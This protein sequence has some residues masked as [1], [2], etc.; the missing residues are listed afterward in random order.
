M[1]VGGLVTG[2][3]TADLVEQLLAIERRPMVQ[4][5]QRKDVLSKQRDAWRDINS[6]LNTLRERM[7]SL[8]TDKLFVSRAATASNESVL[9]VSAGSKAVSGSYEI[10]VVQLAKAHTVHLEPDQN[11]NFPDL[12]TVNGETINVNEDDSLADIAAQ[13]NANEDLKVTAFVVGG[14]LVLKSDRT[15]EE[16]SITVTGV[17]TKEVTKAQD[18]IVRVEGEALEFAFSSNTIDDLLEGVT[19]TLKEEGTTVITIQRDFDGVVEAIKDVVAQYNSVQSF[20]SSITAAN[21]AEGSRGV[22]AGDLLAQRIQTDLRMNVMAP[23]GDGFKQLM[24]IGIH[25]DRHG[26][27]TLDES[28]LRAALAEE[29]QMVEWLFTADDEDA[30]GVAVRMENIF[31]NW[32]AS[33]DG[34]LA[35]RQKMFGNQMRTIDDSMERLERRLEMREQALLRQFAALEQVMAAFQSQ[36]LWLEGQ[37]QQLSSL[38]AA[39]PRRN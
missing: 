2:M 21:S 28:K 12:F 15:G 37:L 24:S 6:R 11:G 14:K 18:A 23:V 35:E 38:A 27:M 3:P 32:L 31:Q 39:G 19:L 20:I 26:T 5:Q 9:D 34:L 25:V 16:N 7:A 33:D 13:I 17:Q 30:V 4:M 29:P 10:E 8:R 22:L 1:Y 36:S